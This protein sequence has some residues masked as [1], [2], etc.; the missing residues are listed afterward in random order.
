[1]TTRRDFL[2][3]TA[4]AATLGLGTSNILAHANPPTLATD[5]VIGHQGFT[6]KVDK[7][8]AKISVNST[9]LFNCHEMVQDSK[10]RLIMLGDNVQNNIL[11]FDKSGKLLDNWGTAYA[12]GHGLTL[13]KEGEEDFLYIVDCGWYQ[14][15]T[16][17]WN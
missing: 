16:G 3:K 6:Y 4:L 2:R 8:W 17:K 13:A 9:P 7:N 12:G 11:I 14:D 5:L 10:G 15:R 1:M